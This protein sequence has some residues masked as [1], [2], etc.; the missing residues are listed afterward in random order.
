M[1]S[2]RPTGSRL[3]MRRKPGF[4][5]S[6]GIGCRLFSAMRDHVARALLDPAELAAI[7]HRAAHLLGDLGHHLLVHG[8]QR[9]EEGGDLRGA[10]GDAACCAT[11]SAPRAQP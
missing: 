5:S 10:L 8:E 3:I 7:A 1:T 4:S 9:I 6:A 11:P 2:T